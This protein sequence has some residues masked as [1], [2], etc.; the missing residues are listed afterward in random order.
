MKSNRV[1]GIWKQALCQV[2]YAA[3]SVVGLDTK[4]TEPSESRLPL[5]ASARRPTIPAAIS[6]SK[7]AVYLESAHALGYS[8]LEKLSWEMT[9]NNPQAFPREPGLASINCD[10]SCHGGELCVE[11][12]QAC[13]TDEKAHLS[14]VS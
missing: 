4:L 9:E 1:V 6:P 13:P 5:T 14:P 12:P 8:C 3:D 10:I 2:G 11:T 7:L